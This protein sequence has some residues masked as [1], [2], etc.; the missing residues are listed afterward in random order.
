MKYFSCKLNPEGVHYE[1]AISL[2]GQTTVLTYGPFPFG[3]YPDDSIFRLESRGY[4]S[5]GENALVDRGYRD[6]RC[7][8]LNDT[9][10]LD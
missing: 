3:S 8:T 10:G 2:R 4:L 5:R 6:D 7:F 9:T 1:V